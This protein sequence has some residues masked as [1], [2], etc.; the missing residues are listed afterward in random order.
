MRVV[1]NGTESTSNFGPKIWNIVSE[2]HKKIEQFKQ[3][4]RISQK[5]GTLTVFADFVH[6]VGFL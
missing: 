2:E 5:K 1:D 6:G 3:F 4:E